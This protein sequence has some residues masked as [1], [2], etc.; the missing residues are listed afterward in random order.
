MI[1]SLMPAI[2][3]WKI[4]IPTNPI[5]NI[6][7]GAWHMASNQLALLLFNVPISFNDAIIAAPLGNPPIAL[8][9]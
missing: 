4:S 6:G 8:S 1:K 3:A 9:K 7:L 5:T 2:S